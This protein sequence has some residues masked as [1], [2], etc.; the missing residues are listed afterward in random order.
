MGKHSAKAPQAS[1]AADGQIQAPLPD[2]PKAGHGSSGASSRKFG[3]NAGSGRDKSA[4]TAHAGFGHAG[5]EGRSSRPEVPSNPNA[6]RYSRAKGAG[7]YIEKRRRRGRHHVLRT[8]LVAILAVIVSGGVAVAAYIHHINSTINAGVDTKLRKALVET[9]DPGDPFYMLLLGID[10]DEER[11]DS[12]EYG[13]DYSAYRTDTIILARVD[14]RNKKVTLISIPRDTMID[15]GSHGTQKINAAYSFGGAAYATEVVSKFAGVSISHYAEID[16]DG[17]AEVVDAIGGVTVNLPVAVKDPKYTGLDLPAG[18][19][20]L[21]G[22]T[23]AL[24]GRARHA[25]DSYG[26]GDFYRAA[27]QRMLI[28]AV[29]KKVMSSGAATIVSTV[30]TLAGYVTTDMTVSSITSLATNFAGIDVDKDIYS[31]Q[32]P[33]TSEYVNNTWYEVADADAWAKIMER[34]DK[35]LPPYSSSTQDFT[36]G[37][38]GSVGVSTSTS[39]DSGSSDDSS[40]SGT[41]VTPEYSGTVL[42][43]NGTTTAGV[44][45]KGASTLSSAGFTTSTNDAPSVQSKTAVYYNGDSAANAAGVAKSLGLSVAPVANDGNWD[46]SVDVVVVFGTD[47][48]SGTATATGTASATT[49]GTTTTSTGN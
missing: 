16:M 24:L 30:N 26:G 40:S 20:T 4:R 5:R 21:D 3:F 47:W 10:K 36:A 2:V 22:K 17:F 28:G 37:V 11:A 15:M 23:A 9:K 48:T 46:S 8:V 1:G 34:V 14:P 7:E 32:C 44:A 45:G 12:A 49:T 19:Q 38:A 6:P 25:Y 41:T 39:D 31:G 42:V 18:K 29:I 13:K 43:L 33:T 35:G 27:N